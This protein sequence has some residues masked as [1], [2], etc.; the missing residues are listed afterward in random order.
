MIH[1]QSNINSL[2]NMDQVQL[3]LNEFDFEED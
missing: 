1:I 2:S 3:A